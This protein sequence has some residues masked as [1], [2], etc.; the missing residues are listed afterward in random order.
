M[1]QK[2]TVYL[3]V[4]GDYITA[5][6]TF[7]NDWVHQETVESKEGY[8]FT[9]EQ[10]NEYTQNVIKQA[11]ETA[12]EKA[13]IEQKGYFEAT[14]EECL[15]GVEIYDDNGSDRPSFIA[16]LN[17]Q[18]ILNTFEETFKLFKV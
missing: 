12:A 10:L 16:F 6:C 3:P 17:K 14:P 2:Q 9:P 1:I 4:N 18:S 7:E 5:V 8:F 11:L 13:E 15:K